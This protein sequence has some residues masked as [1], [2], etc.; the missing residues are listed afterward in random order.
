MIAYQSTVFVVLIT[1]T[2]SSEWTWRQSANGEK[3]KSTRGR[4]L[5]AAGRLFAERGFNSVSMPAI[6][7]ASGITAGAIY[8]HFA[9]KADLFF[10]V[11]KNVVQSALPTEE[12]NATGAEIIPLAV[13]QYTQRELKLLRQLSLEI[14]SAS[15]T[16]LKVRRMLSR[17]L[18]HNVD[19][20]R[21]A[22]EASQKRGKLDSALD[23]VLL[24]NL[25]IALIMGLSH[26][27]TLAPH[28]IGDQRWGEF[29]RERVVAMIGLR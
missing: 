28:L 9:S 18:E 1:M 17:A 11:V 15:R 26:L 21:V 23:S 2:F 22:I 13:A 5:N 25:V 20:L 16:H 29:V 12:A 19:Q 7:K 4:I 8:K 24:A 3:A 14:H 6:A 10:E 27:E